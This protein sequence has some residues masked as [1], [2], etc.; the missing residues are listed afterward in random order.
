MKCLQTL[1][2]ITWQALGQILSNRATLDQTYERA[3]LCG[4]QLMSNSQ[5]LLKTLVIRL[6]KPVIKEGMQT[7]ALSRRDREKMQLSHD[8]LPKNGDDQAPGDTVSPRG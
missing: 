2:E 8:R 1:L 6:G 3:H 7:L 4:R 5:K